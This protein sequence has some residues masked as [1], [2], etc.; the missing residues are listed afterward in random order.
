MLYGKLIPCSSSECER[1]FSNMNLI[2]NDRRNRLLIENVSNLLFIKMHGPPL[3]IFNP[4]NYVIT[5][6][7]THRS[8]DDNQTRKSSSENISINSLWK[9]L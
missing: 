5:W 4:E 7:Q 2:L 9:L 1:G 8:A 3:N 6:L